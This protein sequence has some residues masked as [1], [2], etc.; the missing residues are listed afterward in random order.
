MRPSPSLVSGKLII[1]TALA[2]SN[3]TGAP[4]VLTHHPCHRTIIS[5]AVK[6]EY[7]IAIVGGGIIGLSIAFTAVEPGSK[8]AIIDPAPGRGTTWVA[9]GMLAPVTEAYYGEEPELDLSLAAAA[10]WPSFAEALEHESGC[11]IGYRQVGTMV[12]AADNDDRTF[13]KELYD[14]QANMGLD[15]QW[16]NPSEARELVPQLAPSTRGGLLARGDYQVDPR[17]VA[18]ALVKVAGDR[19]YDII[20]ASA[21][22]VEPVTTG[23][24]SIKLDSGEYIKAEK[25]VLCTGAWTSQV[26]G[27]PEY[28]STAI[29]P[30]KGEIVRVSAPEPSRLPSHTV[31]AI[32]KGHSVYM[33]PRLDGT[34]VIG[35]TM[36]EKGF[37]T[38]VRSGAVYELLRDAREIL[39]VAG[40]LSFDEAIAGLRPATPD[41]GPLIGYIDG[42]GAVG[43]SSADSG[44]GAGAGHGRPGTGKSLIVAA[45]HYRNGV[46]LAPIT[47][48]AVKALL[49]GDV[50]NIPPEVL[51]FSPA[52]FADT[53]LTIQTGYSRN[54]EPV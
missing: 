52:R 38:S 17:L 37:D 26:P 43:T 1:G 40:E 23:D 31:R 29:R 10:R 4:A 49:L 48:E 9:A 44:S 39:P 33:V 34:L 22:S 5:I 15:V 20:R 8:V 30:V 53:G 2:R 28:I 3:G 42:I 46:L 54:R 13:I 45:G 35:A 14:F 7:S 27:I 18:D 25:V 36:E 50:G 24:H 16:L 21:T 11:R 6:N 32:A 47:A 12:V 51:P 19:T 41:N